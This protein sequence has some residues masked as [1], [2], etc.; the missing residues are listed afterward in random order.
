MRIK[1]LSWIYGEIVEQGNHEAL[2]SVKG[3]YYKLV[4]NQLE[5]SS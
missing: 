4:K 1:S 5:L 3:K 2:I